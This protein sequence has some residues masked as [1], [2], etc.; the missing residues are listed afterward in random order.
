MNMKALLAMLIILTCPGAIAQPKAYSFADI[1]C[2][3]HKQQWQEFLKADEDCVA[4]FSDEEIALNIDHLYHLKIRSTTHLPNGGII[5]LCKDERQEDVTITLIGDERMFVY[6]AEKRFLINFVQNKVA[7]AD[8]VEP[9]ATAGPV[10][11]TVA[12]AED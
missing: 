2:R 10:L 8:R 4:Y 5:Y 9:K 12:N 1:Q 3:N 7:D 6:N 11:S